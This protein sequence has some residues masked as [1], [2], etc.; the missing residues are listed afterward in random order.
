MNCHLRVCSKCKE[1]Y[2]CK[3]VGK[4]YSSERLC[5]TCLDFFNG[6]CEMIKDANPVEDG[7]CVICANTADVYED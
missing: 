3:V 1:I 4:T 2:G 7:K 6:M 5:D